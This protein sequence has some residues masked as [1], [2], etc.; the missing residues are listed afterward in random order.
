MLKKVTNE[1]VQQFDD[2]PQQVENTPKQV[3]FER[4]IINPTVNSKLGGDTPTAEEL[5]DE[6]EVST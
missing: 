1:V 4:R 5:S 6:E 3:E 2:A